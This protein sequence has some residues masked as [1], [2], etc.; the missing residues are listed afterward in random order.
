MR[1]TAE[2]ELEKEKEGTERKGSKG[3]SMSKLQG[4]LFASKSTFVVLER[5]GV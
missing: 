5:K 3:A 2:K 4:E 1:G